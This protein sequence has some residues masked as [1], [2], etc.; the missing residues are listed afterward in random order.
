MKPPGKNEWV[1]I[2]EKS[3]FDSPF[4][5]LIERHCR[6]SEDASR[7]Y[8][9]YVMRSCDW[10]NVIPVTEDGKVVLVKQ[11]RIGSATH[12]LEVPGGVMDPAD[13]TVEAAAQRELEEETGYTLL[14]G[15]RWI[16][17][18][19][20]LANPAIQN[21][22]CFNLIVGPVKRTVTQNLDPGE[23]IEIVEMPIDEL[24]ERLQGGELD[25][26]LMWNGFFQ[27]MLRQKSGR[28]LLR[29]ELE[30]FTRGELPNHQ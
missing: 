4:V 1:C 10:C 17:L 2:E 22:R 29:R 9:F 14:P 20:P 3:V 7:E 30:L 11:Y 28:D 23:M 6:S 26:A 24:P 13:G 25:H 16:R 27:L 19:S 8:R 5:K 18:A 21:N 12:T 15:A